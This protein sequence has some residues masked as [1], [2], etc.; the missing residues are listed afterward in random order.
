MRVSV[1]LCTYNRSESLR[2]ALESVESL[3]I[4]EAVTWEVIVVDNNSTDD[5]RNTIEEFRRKSILPLRYLFE[6]GRGKSYALNSGI[7]AA[8]GDIVALTDDDCIV[9]ERWLASVVR[10]FQSDPSLSVVG[11]RV[12]L[13]DKSDRP[14]S[15]RTFRDRITL[16]STAQLF[17]LIPGCNMAVRRAV[18][19]KVGEFDVGFG[20]GTA[21]VVDDVDF[22]FRA[23]KHGLKIVYSPDVLLY[24]NHGRRTDEQVRALNR[25]YVI[26][27]GGFYCKHILV[28][29]RDVLKMAYWEIGSLIKASF[30]NLSLGMSIKQERAFL[31]YLCRGAACQLGNMMRN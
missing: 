14:V 27:R 1:I 9:D 24:H 31:A 30:K 22:V 12:E 8:E 5:T 7:K 15:I 11:G 3:I 16:G 26:G 28:G 6:K 13:Y 17:S 18:F 25:S 2:R 20:P 4:P 23:F 10:E 29:D 19:G 21:I